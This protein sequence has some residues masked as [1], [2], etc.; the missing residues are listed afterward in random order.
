MPNGQSVVTTESHFPYACLD[1]YFG[2]SLCAYDVA[3][4]NP[5]VV[6][7]LKSHHGV[8]CPADRDLADY[9]VEYLTD[10]KV[11]KWPRRV[12]LQPS[13]CLLKLPVA[14]FA[15]FLTTT[16]CKAVTTLVLLC[17]CLVAVCGH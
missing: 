7:F 6:N 11:K 8:V 2:K 16:E 9:F 3:L 17:L 15:G 5:G 12:A 1:V 13:V 14:V 10:P 4:S